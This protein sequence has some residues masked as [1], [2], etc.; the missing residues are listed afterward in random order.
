MKKIILLFILGVIY[1]VSLSA[2]YH[3]K[4][5]FEK[6]VS[7]E[8]LDEIKNFAIVK[9]YKNY[10]KG[11]ERALGEGISESIRKEWKAKKD[12]YRVPSL[13]V[14]IHRFIYDRTEQHLRK[15]SKNFYYR[16]RVQIKDPVLAI[17]GP[18]VNLVQDFVVEPGVVELPDTPMSKIYEYAYLHATEA[19][20]RLLD[21]LQRDP[22]GSYDNVDDETTRR[23]Y[24]YRSEIMACGGLNACREQIDQKYGENKVREYKKI[25]QIREDWLFYKDQNPVF[26]LYTLNGDFEDLQFLNRQDYDAL[27]TFFSNNEPAEG[28]EYRE[29]ASPQGYW[30]NPSILN[31]NSSV[32]KGTEII[33]RISDNLEANIFPENLSI[34]IYKA[35]KNTDVTWKNSKSL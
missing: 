25:L 30:V 27:V 31:H 9:N 24:E 10:N 17:L 7:G 23:A 26:T 20:Q 32:I 18:V 16:E 15:A 14:G 33:I 28:W 12:K 21:N 4:S 3:Q 35:L 1:P 6:W 29:Y 22:Y 13:T 2:Q 34:R 8:R 5:H 11:M 19:R